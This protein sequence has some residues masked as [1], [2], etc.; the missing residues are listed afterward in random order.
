MAFLHHQYWPISPVINAGVTAAAPSV[1]AWPITQ[2]HLHSIMIMIPDGHNGQ[3]GVKIT[4]QQQQIIPWSNNAWLIAS[5]QTLTFSWEEEIMATGLDLVAYN[6][7]TV[8]HQFFAYADVVPQLGEAPASVA[9][10]GL[11]SAPSPQGLVTIGAL[12]G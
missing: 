5:G 2:G 12:S 9:G 11:L 10:G 4:Y 8:P 3:T 7:D 6:T 1:S